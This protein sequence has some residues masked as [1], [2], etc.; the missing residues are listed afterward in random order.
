MNYNLK[1]FFIS[2]KLNNHKFEELAFAGSHFSMPKKELNNILLAELDSEEAAKLNSETNREIPNSSIWVKEKKENIFTKMAKR[3]SDMFKPKPLTITMGKN[4]TREI[5]GI[6]PDERKN[7]FSS[8]IKG[9]ATKFNETI[10]KAQDIKKA[11]TIT[12]TPEIYSTALVEQPNKDKSAQ[13]TKNPDLLI[14]GNK[15]PI[16]PQTSKV[17]VASLDVDG[18]EELEQNKNAINTMAKNL[19]ETKTKAPEEQTPV[20]TPQELNQDDPIR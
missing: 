2:V 20:V 13:K 7:P 6:M 1:D 10:Q 4:D 9:I 16:I 15:N 19:T 17:E 14:P 18:K 12:N 3:I 8:L 5:D 11:N